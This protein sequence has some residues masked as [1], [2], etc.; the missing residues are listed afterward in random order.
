[1]VKQDHTGLVEGGGLGVALCLDL[2]I[3]MASRGARS[4]DD[5]MR[6]LFSRH[7]AEDRRYGLADV[8]RYVEE[9]RGEDRAVFFGDYV[10]GTGTL[11]IAECLALAGLTWSLDDG[12]GHVTKS[13]Q[14]TEPQRH[15][16]RVLRGG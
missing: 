4:L 11:P 2:D 13:A 16:L 7:D 9:I 1:P 15:I 5:V 14:P 6:L 3:R 8:E 12:V 10:A